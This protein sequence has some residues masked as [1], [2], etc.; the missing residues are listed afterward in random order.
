MSAKQAL[1]DKLQGSVTAHLRC[2]GVVNNLIKN[3]YCWVWEWK[4]IKVGEYLAKL[5]AG[6]WLSRALYSPFA[7][8]W[9]DAKSARDNHVDRATATGNIINM[10]TVNFVKA[11]HT[12]LLRYANEPTCIHADKRYDTRCYFNVRSKADISRL[13]LPHGTDN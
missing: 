12:K 3:V 11:E 6:T 1:N 9:P 13:N 8:C 2:G 5:Q 10:S 7:V 4:K